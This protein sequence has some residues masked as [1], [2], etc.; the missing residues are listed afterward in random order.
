VT[1]ESYEEVAELLRESGEA[2]RAVRPIG[3]GTK[4]GWDVDQG[5]PKH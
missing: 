4:L 3:A 2:G 5:G 1:P